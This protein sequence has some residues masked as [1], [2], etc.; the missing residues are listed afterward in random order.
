VTVPEEHDA[1]TAQR[2]R[3]KLVDHL[4]AEEVIQPGQ[5]EAAMRVVPR[6]IFVPDA[7]LSEAYA[8]DIVRTKQDDAGVAISAASQSRI[9]RGSARPGSR[10][11]PA[12]TPDARRPHVV[13]VDER[14]SRVTGPR[15]GNRAPLL[16]HNGHGVIR[17][18]QV[19]L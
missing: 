3:D 13:D 9:G 5:I 14:D 2:L 16:R 7:A 6:H 19:G 1:V 17:I 15:Q 10:P 11:D 8:D 18:R 12:R 4:L